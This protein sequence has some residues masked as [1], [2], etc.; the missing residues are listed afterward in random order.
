M[1]IFIS[2][3]PQTKIIFYQYINAFRL[4]EN[5]LSPII[6]IL[7]SEFHE[8]NQA[9]IKKQNILYIYKGSACSTIITLNYIAQE[10]WLHWQGQLQLTVKGIH[11]HQMNNYKS[12]N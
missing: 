3:F 8:L 7:S 1:H 6:V 10:M 11:Y 4:V 12:I 5:I 2:N 9:T